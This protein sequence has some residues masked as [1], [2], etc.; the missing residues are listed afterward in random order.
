MSTITVIVGVKKQWCE[1]VKCT[2][3]YC[4]FATVTMPVGGF[5]RTVV[6]RE[7]STRHCFLS[8]PRSL[9][10]LVLPVQTP[11]FSLVDTDRNR[12][13]LSWAGEV[14]S[15]SGIDGGMSS[16]VYVSR[17]VLREN[18]MQ[19]GASGVLTQVAVPP[20]CS[21]VSALVGSLDQWEV[22]ALNA[23]V[24]QMAFL[25]QVRVVGL[26]QRVPL[27]LEGGACVTLK[28]VGL[29]PPVSHLTLHPMSQVEVLPPSEDQH[30]PTHTALNFAPSEP[31]AHTNT[32]GEEHHKEETNTEG[33]SRDVLTQ[34]LQFMVGKLKDRRAMQSDFPIRQDVRLGARVVGLP[35]LMVDSLGSLTCHPSLVIINKDSVSGTV[36]TDRVSFLASIRVIKSPKDIVEE[37]KK[38]SSE[39]KQD[40][41]SREFSGS[42]VC[43]VIVWENYIT[44]NTMQGSHVK[45]V[46]VAVKG[47]NCVVP[48]GLRRLMK[49]SDFTIIEIQTSD[50]TTKTAPVCVDV[51]AITP[52]TDAATHSPTLLHKIKTMVKNLT[53]ECPVVINENTLLEVQLNDGKVIDVLLRTRDGVPLQLTRKSAVLLDVTALKEPPDIPH[54]LGST[55]DLTT[56]YQVKYPYVGDQ[57]AL[58][59]L[60]KHI[61]FSLVRCSNVGPQFGLLQGS[62]G[63][64]K[65]GLMESLM[66]SLPKHPHHV[67][68]SITSLK[69][70][71]GKKAE[72]IE[73]KLQLVFREAIFRRP[74]VVFLDDLD[75]LVPC[76]ASEEQHESGPLHTYSMQVVTV[77][78]LIL[79]QLMEFL[80]GESSVVSGGVVVVASCG[81]RSGIHPLL[82]NPQGCHYFPCTFTI[83]P[84]GPDG[85]VTAFRAMLTNHTRHQAPPHTEGPSP[86]GTT[87][88]HHYLALENKLLAKRTESFTLP[89]LN[90]LALRTYL[91]ARD[92]WRLRARVEV[93]K[94]VQGGQAASSREQGKVL[95]SDLET[96][97][98]GYTPLA[99]RGEGGGTGV[100]IIVIIIIINIIF[101]FIT[102]F[103]I[104]IG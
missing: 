63:S 85:R 90:H 8:L 34:I 96:A 32:P 104:L 23:E 37:E 14:H 43:T 12:L 72:T 39:N 80:S 41:S 100:I 89:D 47:G 66:E 16:E 25:N 57:E 42:F 26:G 3:V 83:P 28:V 19:D 73:R 4:D 99:L 27:W 51:L 102:H 54:I 56:C 87:Q 10:M 13:L 79:D 94:G 64:G 65:T 30:S 7:S 82:V 6:V 93:N 60:R 70:L 36:L 33:Q 68:C 29:E 21:S 77:F 5:S 58:H 49:L 55:H 88:L 61:L 62:R 48:S 74:S 17:E 92:R 2:V 101:I 86:Q 98:Q 53:E 20:Q 9:A 91:C 45:D 69:V 52:N 15:Y 24:A 46:S 97:L 18:G 31:P 11:T 76:A 40:K 71:K 44:E 95:D 35:H 1:I 67:H 84:L 59:R 50:I 38:S 81:S 103:H 78:K 22:L 75:S